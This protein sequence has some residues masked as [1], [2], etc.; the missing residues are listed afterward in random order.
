MAGII[1]K[2]GTGVKGEKGRAVL[3]GLLCSRNAR[4]QKALVGRA[5]WEINRP[6]SCEEEI[7]KFGRIILKDK[8]HS[9]RAVKDLSVQQNFAGARV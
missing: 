4:P 9:M 5:Q 3:S 1:A 6:P 2:R 8:D 7:S